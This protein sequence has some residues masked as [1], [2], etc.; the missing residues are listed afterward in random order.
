MYTILSIVLATMTKVQS[1]RG[2]SVNK[3]SFD[4]LIDFRMKHKFILSILC[5]YSATAFDFFNLR[6]F[7][8]RKSF[9]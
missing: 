2:F 9:Q 5:P 1:E 7:R 8:V 6:V 4:L 3:R